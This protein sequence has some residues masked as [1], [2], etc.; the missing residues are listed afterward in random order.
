MSVVV[1]SGWA[2]G[3][4][5][6]DRSVGGISIDGTGVVAQRTQ[7]A[8]V[9]HRDQMLEE[10]QEVPVALGEAVELRKVSLRGLSAAIQHA[11]QHNVGVLP[12]EVKYLAGIQRIKYVFVYPEHNDIVLAGPGEGWEVNDNGDVVGINTGLPVLQI[13][14]LLVALRTVHA[15]RDEGISC[16][17]DPTVEGRRNYASYVKQFK[18]FDPSITKGAEEALGMQQI[19]LTGIP[20]D[21]HFARVLVAAD[22]RMKRI[23]MKL[24]PS[25][26]RELPS[27]LDMIRSGRRVTNVMPRWWLAAN[28]EPLT[29]SEDGLAWEISGQGVRAMTEDEFVT[30]DGSVTGTGKADPI[31]QRWADRLTEKY[32]ELARRETVFAELRN[33]M[34]LA[35]VAALIES[36]GLMQKAGCSLAL[37]TESRSDAMIDSWNPP[38]SIASQCSFEK[39]GR[40]YIL[41]AS[42]GVQIESWQTVQQQ[43]AGVHVGKVRER[44]RHPGVAQWYWD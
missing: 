3:R 2:G 33:L 19:T 18:R 9:Q 21:S 39:V 40:T 27:F 34:D 42:G 44:Q 4:F 43:I 30:A 38:S 26:V 17:I 28:Y 24:D 12:D 16:S 36:E 22:Y 31:A 15:A 7:E 37:L 8:R 32:E 10:L 11:L 29:R 41:T 25:P 6:R 1:E 13:D 5:F 20:T 23:A 35:V 14:D